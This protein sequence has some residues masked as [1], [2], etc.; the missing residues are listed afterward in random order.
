M[1]FSKYEATANDFIMFDCTS[2]ELHL[3]SEKV[4][5]LCDRRTGVGADGVIV[6]LASDHA[7]MMMRIFNADGSEAQMCGNGIRALFLFALDTGV[8]SGEKVTV[9][10][11][12]GVKT[13]WKTPGPEGGDL[14]TVNIGSPSWMQADIPMSGEGEAIGVHL[15]L[16]DG[17]T[18]KATCVSMGNPHCVIFVDSIWGHP[19]AEIGPKVETHW[20][21]PER[22][23]VEF[24][25]VVN[26]E[27]LEVRVWERGVGETMSCGTGA[28]AS[29]VAANLI[30][31]AGKRATVSLSGGDLVA[32]WL[33][34]GVQL[35]G[36]ARHVFDGKTV[37]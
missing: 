19:V 1:E 7:D 36:P 22:T 21:F 33:E 8:T 26:G 9:D 24:V 25:H 37:D 32:N 18:L 23:N 30:K 14:F 4:R 28:C 16:D 10:T 13:V 27:H 2:G 15:D 29:L 20:L 5:A 12:A 11:L 31:K 17:T 6:L 3:S 35:T 34:D